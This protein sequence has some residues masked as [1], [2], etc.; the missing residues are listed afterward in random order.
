MPVFLS[1]EWI[2][3]LDKAARASEALTSSAEARGIVIEQRVIGAP[4]GEITYHLVLGTDAR[5]EAGPAD[6]PDVVLVTDYETAFELQSGV[7]NAQRAIAAGRMKIQGHVGVL[8]QHAEALRAFGDVFRDV[9]A[10]TEA[11]GAADPHR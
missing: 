7:L 4:S 11:P 3:E 6:T 8:L 5:V 9:R 2:R 1:P 10:S